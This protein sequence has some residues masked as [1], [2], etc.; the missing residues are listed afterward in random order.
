MDTFQPNVSIVIP[1]YNGA[2]YVAQAIESALQQSYPKIEVLVV[3]DGSTDQGATTRIAQSFG[4]RIRYFEKPNGGVA[5]ALNLGIEKMTGDYFSWLSHDDLYLPEK[6]ATQVEILGSLADRE[7]VLYSD[8]HLVDEASRVITTV[9][10]DHQMLSSKPLYSV[11]RGSVHGCSTLVPRSAFERFGRFDPALATTQDYALWFKMAREI[12]F[13]HT[14]VPLISSR[15][16]AAQG[17]KTHPA[18]DREANALWI[19]FVEA[20]SAQEMLACE[21]TVY[22][23][24]Q[25]LEKFLS[26]TPYRE[27]QAFVEAR[28]QAEREKVMATLAGHKVSVV[29][30]APPLTLVA[31]ALESALGQSHSN[32]E[33]LIAGAPGGLEAIDDRIRWLETPV[34]S[35]AAARNL[36]VQ[37]AEGE[38]LAFLDGNATWQPDKLE[39][40]LQ[41]MLLS[42][43]QVSYTDYVDGAVRVHCAVSAPFY[44]NLIK[45]GKIQAATVM[46]RSRLL[47]ENPRFR[48]QPGPSPSDQACLWLD[49]ARE[50]TFQHFATPLTRLQVG[51]EAD[52]PANEALACLTVV[53]HLQQRNVLLETPLEVSA[54]LKTASRQLESLAGDR[55]LARS[56]IEWPQAPLSSRL[57][58]RGAAAYWA[59]PS[60]LRPA[61]SRLAGR[62]MLL[63]ERQARHEHPRKERVARLLQ[64]LDFKPKR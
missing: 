42:G 56:D 52:A 63:L 5:T 15:W 44:P 50:V 14:P 22:R 17:S 1:V 9:R 46:M 39:F 33:V 2:D 34:D 41:E 28:A 24:H 53:A 27:A 20:L 25:E 13:H 8:Y 45:G 48:F 12:P 6:V 57:A 51:Q 23:F 61:F 37:A 11:L 19:G 55:L 58:R 59:V 4:E 38:F 18:V 60:R 3:N 35:M 30:A 62:F 40:Q 32:L 26:T 47:Q 10:L 29:L 36:G 49:L 31:Q 54:L 43:A 16:H 64:R 7:T 21:P